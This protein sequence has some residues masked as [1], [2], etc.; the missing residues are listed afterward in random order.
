MKEP[1][2]YCLVVC[3]YCTVPRTYP[4]FHLSLEL[5]NQPTSNYHQVSRAPPSPPSS[6]H[7]KTTNKKI[8]EPKI[9]T[10]YHQHPTLPY[11]PK[12]NSSIR[13]RSKIPNPSSTVQYV[14]AQRSHAQQPRTN[15]L[16]PKTGSARHGDSLVQT[17]DIIDWLLRTSSLEKKCIPFSYL[18]TYRTYL[19]TSTP[20]PPSSPHSKKSS[21]TYSAIPTFP[22]SHDASPAHYQ[23]IPFRNRGAD[24]SAIKNLASQQVWEPNRRI[25]WS[26]GQALGDTNHHN[27]T[28]LRVFQNPCLWQAIIAEKRAVGRGGM[29]GRRRL[30]LREWRS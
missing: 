3:M 25:G 23:N 15:R 6:S 13:I 29:M 21:L 5:H 2:Q 10:P 17:K 27:T 26:T 20:H 9:R 19:P 24:R 8:Q 12:D 22:S 16:T 4:I 18:P 11:H 1:S 28:L 14:S 30:K 7:I